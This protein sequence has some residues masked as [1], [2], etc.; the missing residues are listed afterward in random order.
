MPRHRILPPPPCVFPCRHPSI[1]PHQRP[2]YKSPTLSTRIH[3]LCQGSDTR[4]RRFLRS[5]TVVH[6]SSFQVRVLSTHFFYQSRQASG[7]RYLTEHARRSLCSRNASS[8][9]FSFYLVAFLRQCLVYL[10]SSFDIFDL[11]IKPCP[12]SHRF[13]FPISF[14]PSPFRCRL[15]VS[16]R[17]PRQP[18]PISSIHSSNPL[19][20]SSDHLRVPPATSL[21]F[22]LCCRQCI[23]VF[24]FYI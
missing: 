22:I 18:F 7:S 4:P 14:R 9:I 23:L 21:T 11:V 16:R 8:F 19:F 13:L 5:S 15:S 12:Q 17:Y 24:H 20:P 1:H 2:R 3:P 10:R 6:P